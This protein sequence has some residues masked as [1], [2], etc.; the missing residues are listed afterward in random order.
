MATS[1]ITS[2]NHR[3]NEALLHRAIVDRFSTGPPPH[4]TQPSWRKTG[5]LHE[6][7]HR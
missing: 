4:M 6:R 1:Y 2:G 3:P 7:N 5:G